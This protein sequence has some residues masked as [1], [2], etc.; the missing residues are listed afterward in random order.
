MKK[1][2]YLGIYQVYVKEISKTKNLNEISEFFIDKVQKHPFAKYIGVFNHYAHT[3]NIDGKI[4]ENINGANNVLFC[5]GGKLL[6]PRV[7]SARPRSIGICETNTH[8]VISFMEA[9]N[10]KLTAIMTEWVNELAD[11]LKKR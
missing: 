5:F 7:L 3:K 10:L 11:K 1:N 8:F 2:N 9:P 6:D 4:G